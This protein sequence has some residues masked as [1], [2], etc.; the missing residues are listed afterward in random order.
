MGSPKPTLVDEDRLASQE[1]ISAA[2]AAVF[3][4][5]FCATLL[6]NRKAITFPRNSVIYEVESQDRTLFFLQSGF[7]KIG[8]VTPVGSEVIYEIRKAGDVVGELCVCEFPRPD[9]AVTLE[10]TEVIP[11]PY[12]DLIDGLRKNPD[13]LSTLL[14]VLC[15]ALTS[16]YQQIVNLV[17]D[18]TLHRL[19]KVLL[20]LAANLGQPTGGEV[21][22]PTY[23]TQEDMAHMVSARRERTSTALNFLRR[24]GVV[25]YSSRGRLVL[26][27]EGLRTYST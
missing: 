12:Q 11:V 9:R 15:K 27:V 6:P 2:L 23:L 8:T 16:A 24:K 21:E 3:R 10:E 19:V 5:K 4:G 14:E 13:L 18:D 26:N 17:I 1:A 20:D 7:V 22:L 25:K